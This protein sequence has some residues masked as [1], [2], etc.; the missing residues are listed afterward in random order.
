MA[1]IKCIRYHEREYMA[2]RTTREK[3]HERDCMENRTREKHESGERQGVHG[4]V[5]RISP[6]NTKQEVEEFTTKHE[7]GS[8]RAELSS[9][10]HGTLMFE[11]ESR[12]LLPERTGQIEQPHD[13]RTID[14]SCTEKGFCPLASRTSKPHGMSA[15]TECPLARSTDAGRGIR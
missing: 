4:M 2:N 10:N 13:T 9:L 7:T 12:M 1:N 11:S 6:R 3:H 8:R 15:C 14:L 5:A